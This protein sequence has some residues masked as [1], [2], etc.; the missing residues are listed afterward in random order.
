MENGF[1]WAR[2]VV[3][4]NWEIVEVD[5]GDIWVLGDNESYTEDEFEFGE[6]IVCDE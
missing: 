4:Q 5:A 1:Y 6:E 3:P 2:R